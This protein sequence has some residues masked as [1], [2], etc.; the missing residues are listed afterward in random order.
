MAKLKKPVPPPPDSPGRHIFLSYLSSEREF[1]LRLAST[2]KNGGVPLWMDVLDVGIKGGDDW[3]R[4]LER[5]VDGSAGVVAVLSPDYVR[6]RYCRRELMRADGLG[7]LIL[8]VLLR[9]LSPKQWPLEIQ[10]KQYVDFQKWREPG[11]FDSRCAELAALLRTHFATLVADAPDRETRYLNALIAD[12][13]SRR[14]VGQFVEMEAA[15]EKAGARLPVVDDEWGFS[16]LVDG[17]DD[18]QAG[19]PLAL[20]DV[21]AHL[22]QFALL[23]VPGAGKT[24]ALR[25]MALETARRRQASPRLEPLPLLKYLPSW[26]DDETLTEFVARDWPFETQPLEAASAGDVEL[27]FD[28]LNEMGREGA[29]HAKALA[30]WLAACGGARAVVT[31]RLANYRNELR[32]GELPRVIVEPLDQPAIEQF[33]S[34]YLG[35]AASRFLNAIGFNAN[36]KALAA[37]AHNP[38]MLSALTYLFERS[39]DGSLPHNEGQLFQRLVRALWERERQRATPGWHPLPE[40]QAAFA[41][42]GFEM[43][44]DNRPI[45][46]PR[47][48]AIERLGDRQLLE[49]GESASILNSDST[50]VRFFHQLLQEYFAATALGQ[51]DLG[52]ALEKPFRSVR[53]GHRGDTKWDRALIMLLGITSS[54]D[55]VMRIVVRVI[56]DVLVVALQSMEVANPAALREQVC[57]HLREAAGSEDWEVRSGAVQGLGE[58]R[59]RTAV[60]LLMD[61]LRDEYSQADGGGYEWKTIYPVRTMAARALGLIVDPSSVPALIAAMKDVNN[62]WARPNVGNINVMTE[63]I[64]AL[65]AIGTPEALAALKG[66]APPIYGGDDSL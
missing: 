45:D 16:L 10:E 66:S 34:R 63:A 15:S 36:A 50:N 2:L 24:T 14:G 28:G 58:L 23:G 62:D 33:V 53:Y 13:E 6:S 32:L 41:R 55:D 1:A 12:L 27:Y 49:L 26:R 8:P 54:P 48:W 42:L 11:V 43:I 35:P 17:Q 9:K 39:P 44:R 46:V 65:R 61:L 31:C 5:A 3:V 38:Y 56:P 7:K 37:L 19:K 47:D 20:R 18:G 40:A 64:K 52:R 60:Q 4:A 30:G 51:M 59:D 25:H 22:R 21:A 29:D 57:Q